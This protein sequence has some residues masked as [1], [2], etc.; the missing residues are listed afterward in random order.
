[1]DN[2]KYVVNV[3]DFTGTSQSIIQNGICPYS[4]KTEAE[5][6]KAGFKILTWEELFPLIKKHENILIGKWEEVKEETFEDMLN[7]LPPLK[8]SNGGFFMSEFWTGNITSFYQRIDERYYT[9]LQ[10]IYTPRTEIVAN[11]REYIANSKE[12]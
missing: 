5:Y 3:K 12:A 9:S 11:L 2:P 4:G 7:C 10:R 1:M 8:W 6:I